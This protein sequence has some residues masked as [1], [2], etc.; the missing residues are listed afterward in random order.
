[1]HRTATNRVRAFATLVATACCAV[2]AACTADA[3]AAQSAQVSGSI[4]AVAAGE[5]TIQTS[6]KPVGVLNALTSAANRI[7][8][9]NLPYVWGG[10][11]GEAGVA[12]VGERGGPGYNGKRVGFDC[13]GAVTAVLVAGGLWPEGQGV[14]NDAGV[15]KYLLK[16]KLIAPGAGTGPTEVTLYD[17]P[18]VHIFMNIDG[19]FWGTSDGGAG[20]DPKG[21]PSWLDDGAWDATNNHYRRYHFVASVL[22][23][24]TAAGYSLTFNLG[25]QTALAP[26]LGIGSQI[27]VAYSTS[28]YGTMVASAVN[29]VNESTVSGAVTAITPGGSSFTIQS[30][31]GVSTTFAV[32][33]GS[34]VA[35]QILAGQLPVGAVV[36]VAYLTTPTPPSTSPGA[37]TI[38]QPTST[39]TAL[40]VTV[41]TPPPPNVGGVGLTGTGTTTTPTQP[42]AS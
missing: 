23:A 26:G 20:A 6:G 1:M 25:P 38:A 41:T 27:N 11:H 42:P 7:G 30:S 36:T 10:G 24:K 3:Q 5:F 33:S 19:R 14:P 39:L 37:T 28:K 8:A 34:T 29:Y 17:D 16:Q 13:S 32:S 22:R 2:S 21:G 9:K 35:Q 18:G 40:T 15:V 4:T 12:S 31:T